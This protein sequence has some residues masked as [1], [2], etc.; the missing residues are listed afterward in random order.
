MSKQ[1]TVFLGKNQDGA[2]SVACGAVVIALQP[3]DMD[4]YGVL[5][6]NQISLPALVLNINSFLLYIDPLGP[7]N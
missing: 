7:Q 3:E 1:H 4:H 5:H 6:V 2:A